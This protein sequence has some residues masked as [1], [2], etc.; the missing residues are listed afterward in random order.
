MAS[1]AAQLVALDSEIE[2]F[3][4]HVAATARDVFAHALEGAS[5]HNQKSLRLP[6]LTM[7]ALCNV[8]DVLV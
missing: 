3:A 4:A 7:A 6:L 5:D 8:Q 1:L 2:N